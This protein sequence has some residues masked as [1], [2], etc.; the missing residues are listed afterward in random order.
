M[1]SNMIIIR[2]NSELKIFAKLIMEDLGKTIPK[3]GTAEPEKT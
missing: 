1:K 2:I 3:K